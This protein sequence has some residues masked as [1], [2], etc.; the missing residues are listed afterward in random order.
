LSVPFPRS[1]AMWGERKLHA[2]PLQPPSST[3]L[4]SAVHSCRIRAT[5]TSSMTIQRCEI[6]WT[7]CRFS[8]IYGPAFRIR[9]RFSLPN[10]RS[11]CV[12]L[13]VWMPGINGMDILRRL[14]SNHAKPSRYHQY[15]LHP[16]R[17]SQSCCDTAK[18]PPPSVEAI[19]HQVWSSAS[20][21]TTRQ[22]MA[23]GLIWRS[24]N[25][26]CF[27]PSASTAGFPTKRAS[28]RKSLLGSST[29]MPTTASQTGNS[30]PKMPVSNSSTFTH[31]SE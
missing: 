31:Q 12:V 11:G 20:N 15:S 24:P 9:S 21:G 22:S 3:H 30:Q 18:L 10:L 4:T 1:E 6:P 14:K 25:S 2:Y 28:S 16:Q 8:R 26:A 27:R 13:D 5:F 29:A 7:F 23:V 19:L 17:C